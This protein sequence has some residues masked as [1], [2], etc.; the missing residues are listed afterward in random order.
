MPKLDYVDWDTT[1]AGDAIEALNH[2]AHALRD[3]ADRRRSAAQAAVAG[4]EGPHRRTFDGHINQAIMEAEDLA[5]T[6]KRRAMQIDQLQ[7]DARALNDKR[8]ES[9][10]RGPR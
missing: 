7:E 10:L 5:E 2:A 6:Y 8:R 9:R 4:W 1:V 3:S